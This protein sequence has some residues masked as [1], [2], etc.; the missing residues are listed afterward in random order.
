MKDYAWGPGWGLEI[1]ESAENEEF[2]DEYVGEVVGEIEY[3]FRSVE[4]TYLDRSY[5]FCLDKT[6]CID[7]ARAANE[8]R[9]INHAKGDKE[10]VTTEVRFVGE[11]PRIGFFAARKIEAGEELFF[12]YGDSF[13]ANSGGDAGASTSSK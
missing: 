3:D 7:S 5:M 6:R 1:E 2:I 9:F 4:G 8:T 11:E 10:N 13:F 12:N